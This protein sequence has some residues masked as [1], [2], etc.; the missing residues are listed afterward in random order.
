MIRIFMH[1]YPELE[2]SRVT[3]SAVLAVSIQNSE[4][5]SYN[6]I[7]VRAAPSKEYYDRLRAQVRKSV[8]V[9]YGR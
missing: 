5:D 9:Q 2:R 6:G 4:E 1:S 7:T 8:A 3:K